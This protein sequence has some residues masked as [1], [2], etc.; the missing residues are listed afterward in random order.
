MRRPGRDTFIRIASLTPSASGSGYTVTRDIATKPQYPFTKG[1]RFY[2]VAAL[3]L[4]D[5]PGEY[6]VD[7]DSGLMHFL[8]PAPM[9]DGT[10][11]VVSLLDT[12]VSATG[13]KHMSWKGMTIS[14]SRGT[15]FDCVGCTNVTVDSCVVTNAGMSCLALGGGNN[16]AINN[17]VFGCGGGAVSI[18][19]GNVTTLTPGHSSAIGNTITNFSRIQRTYA[20]GVAFEGMSNCKVSTLSRF[21]VLSVSLT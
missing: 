1:C 10:D 9:T 13:T 6:H 14:V 4:L 2:A 12:V 7:S 20:A 11:V 8:P 18:Q 17:T 21:A 3:E 15:A 16:S 5:A 19:S